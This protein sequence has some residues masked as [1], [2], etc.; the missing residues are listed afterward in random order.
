[1]NQET[2][3]DHIPELL[4]NNIVLIF[5]ASLILYVLLGSRQV[6]YELTSRSMSTAEILMRFE[7]IVAGMLS[8][9]NIQMKAMT[10]SPVAFPLSMSFA[11]FACLSEPS[12]LPQ[13]SQYSNTLLS[14]PKIQR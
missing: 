1:M 7:E 5:K 10:F 4:E 9:L 14:M 3:T 2:C 11:D 13:P 12:I 6:P 8:H